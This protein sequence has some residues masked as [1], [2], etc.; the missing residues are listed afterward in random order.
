MADTYTSNL[1]LTKPEIGASTDTWGT[2]LNADLEILDGIF[3]AAGSGTSVG[4]QVG[5]GK[6][7][8]VG[9]TLTATGTTTI[10]S[11]VLNTGISGTAFLDEDDMSSNSATKVASQQSIK[12]YVDAQI[13][14]EDLDI[15]DGTN[16][17]A[18]DLD[19]ETL[20]LL[21][22]TG[23]TSTA[24]GNG[25]TFAIDATV[26]TLT[27]SQTLTN[28]TL[29]SPVLNTG[30]SGTAFLDEDNMASNSAT[31]VASQQSIKAYVDS[32]VATADTL[33]EVLT[34]GNTTT[35]DQKIQFRDSGL[36]IN[37]SADGQLD[38]VADTE[39]QIAATTVD[40]NGNLDVSGTL[41]ASGSITGTLGTAAQT[42][43]TSLGTLTTLTVDD[44]TING[45]TISDAADLT[46]DI[47]GDL[48]VDV[49][50]D[51]VWF[52]AGGTRFL[53][54]SQVSSD[55]YIGTEVSDKDM[56]FRGNDGGSSITALTL[57]M[58]DAGTATFNHDIK[59]GDG[60]QAIFGIPGS[61]LQI[62]HSGSHSFI[63]EQGTGGLIVRTGDF[64]LRNPS[65]QD[66]LYA[67][68]G[69]AVTIYH[70]NSA[71]LATSATGVT[72]TGA[73]DATNLTIGGAQGSDGQVLTSTGSGV[74]WEDASGG[75]SS[76]WTT[77][78][79]D[80]YYNTGNVGIGAS[81]PTKAL[82]ISGE[83]AEMLIS[84]TGSYADTINFG[85]PGGVPTMVGGT[86]LA[87]G[88]TGT[89]TEHM[90]IKADGNVGIGTA[91]PG[92]YYADDLV[93]VAADDGGLTLASSATTHK[94]YLVWADGT[95]GSAAYQG[96]LAYD[97]NNNSLQIATAASEAVRID[98]SGNV[99]IGSTS[100]GAKLDVNV[101]SSTA[102]SNTGEPR[103]DIII[104]NT[105]GA[106]GSGVN[107]YASL[108]F[109]VADGATSQGFINYVRTADNQGKFTFS[110]RTGSSSYAE[111]LT[112]LNDGKIGI[113]T[114]SPSYPLDL[115]HGTPEFN[116]KDTSSN[117]Q[118]R[119]SLDG[120]TATINNVSSSGTLVFSNA[121]SEAMRIDS[122]D[123]LAIGKTAITIG[124]VGHVIFNSGA[125]YM[126]TA[127][128]EAL[129]IKKS[130]SGTLSALVFMHEDAT[131]PTVGSVSVTSSA[132]TYNTSSDSRLKDITGEARGLE[133]VNELN[134]V[135]YNWKSN[136]ESDEGLIAQEVKDFV[137]NAV[138]QDEEGYYQMDYS[139]LVTPLIKAV[140]EQQGQIEQLKAE[141]N[142]LKNS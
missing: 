39:V 64:Y 79:S 9:G 133:V 124:D 104:H 4:L 34:N 141:I 136:G 68:S 117:G 88:G 89:W 121:N 96:Y 83:N 92:D 26:A 119:F 58:S 101:N 84:R 90:R 13:T 109:H 29:T 41:N 132:T 111:A 86:D 19:S 14:A 18:I 55:V 7:L 127:G 65:D 16:T 56:I 98:S 51:N 135:A 94:A 103:E 105:N 81:S 57:D 99:G 134:P 95:S 106:D 77:T 63:D 74:A 73:L 85:M 140:Q 114:S 53:S 69:G 44:I 38:I 75:G 40:L 108:G 107:N 118:F 131:P 47:G 33:A 102:Y 8:I 116:M 142:E 46:L 21:G 35:T 139:K 31:K 54:I 62:Y 60:G 67:T 113:G 12:A 5:S 110:Q 28:K 23:L 49:D 42:N 70:N 97:H 25:V 82:T 61:D 27:G 10:T 125:Y 1:N 50:G 91:S 129:T 87:F 36:Y 30:I 122:S 20:S 15:T 128:S 76:Q 17:I 112:I 130:N 137:P 3:V 59:L 78:G 123:N 115:H 93:V 37:S 71:K 100:A 43:I 2:K 22:G 32:Q 126:T 45:S 24:S 72:V 120:T 48:I 66:M 80:I 52:D 6:S 11:P 138:T